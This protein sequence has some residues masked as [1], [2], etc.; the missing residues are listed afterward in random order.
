MKRYK[1]LLV[2]APLMILAGCGGS[3]NQTGLNIPYQGNWTGPW[4]SVTLGQ[5]GTFT[6][7]I[8][9]NGS[10]IG[11]MVNTNQNITGNV[12]GTVD[13][14]G[15][16][17]WNSGMG[18]IGNYTMVGNTALASNGHQTVNFVLTWNGQGYAT[19]ADLAPAAG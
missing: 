16:L 3:G 15:S 11:T 12:V 10:V 17:N 1:N 18:A 9:P 4:T 13:N 5:S 6:V 19:T 14:Q 2:L 8:F 7:Q